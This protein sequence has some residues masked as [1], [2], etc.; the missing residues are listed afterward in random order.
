MQV[1]Q[2]FTISLVNLITAVL[3]CVFAEAYGVYSA[4][5][6]VLSLGKLSVYSLR[7]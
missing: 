5:I 3:E 2:R 1:Y 6:F 4:A 7:Y